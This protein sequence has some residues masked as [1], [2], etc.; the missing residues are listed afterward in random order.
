MRQACAL[1][2][3]LARLVGYKEYCGYNHADILGSGAFAT[4]ALELY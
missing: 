2:V 1:K 4:D 3:H